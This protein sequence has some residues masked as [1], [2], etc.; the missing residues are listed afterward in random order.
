VS[1][2]NEEFEAALNEPDEDEIDMTDEQLTLH[3]ARQGT[4]PEDVNRSVAKAMTRFHVGILRL[5]RE[6]RYDDELLETWNQ[7]GG[8]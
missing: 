6:L 7:E 4:S 1:P 2:T 5:S 8:R 3:L